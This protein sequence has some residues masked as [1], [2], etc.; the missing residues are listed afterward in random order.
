MRVVYINSDNIV[1]KIGDILPPDPPYEFELLIYTS[2]Y[3]E[4]G[5]RYDNG[6]FTPPQ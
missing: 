5:W 2:D 3:C 6:I 4:I 1:T